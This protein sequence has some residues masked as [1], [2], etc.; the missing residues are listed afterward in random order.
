VHGAFI[1][2]FYHCPYHPEGKVERFR[3]AHI[4]RK[5]GP[6]M[7]LRAFADLEIDKDKSFLIGDKQS[8]I[9]AAQVAGI[10]GFLFTGGNLAQ[11]V[12]QCRKRRIGAALGLQAGGELAS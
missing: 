3:L 5:P 12:D 8:D 7:I 1:D 11:F 2:A 4:D 6:G 9:A 10:P